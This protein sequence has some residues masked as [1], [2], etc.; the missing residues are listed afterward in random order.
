M[1]NLYE[2]QARRS[3]P[4]E[5]KVNILDTAVKMFKDGERLI[6]SVTS[7]IKMDNKIFYK[8]ETM[9]NQ[10]A[11]ISNDQF[12]KITEPKSHS[13]MFNFIK[14]KNRIVDKI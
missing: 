5:F 2:F 9:D 14:Q 7:E 8:I 1:E 6:C 13:K 11:T 3:V 12:H 4:V 10:T